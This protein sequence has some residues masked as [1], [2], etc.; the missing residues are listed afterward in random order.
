IDYAIMSAA[1][2]LWVLYIGRILSGVMG[3]TMAV[4]GA[5]IADTME[6]GTRAR[7]FGWLGACYGGGMILGPGLGG[8]LGNVSPTAP[9]AAAAFVTGCMALAVYLLMPRLRPEA[10]QEPQAEGLLKAFLP[11]GVQKGRRSLL[12][13]FFI[14]RL[15][16]QVPAAL[17]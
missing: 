13:L 2:H 6:E 16:G 4:G 17:W 11:S 7:A 1:P 15:V 9:F 12:W 14:L 3:A 5:C 8:A 10:Q